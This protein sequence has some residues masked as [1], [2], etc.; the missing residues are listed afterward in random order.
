MYVSKPI[1]ERV[2]VSGFAQT[3]INF[4]NN[5]APALLYSQVQTSGD[6]THPLVRF[7]FCTNVKIYGNY[8]SISNAACFAG[9][10]I[11]RSSG[12]LIQQNA[13]ESCGICVSIA[14]E[15]ESVEYCIGI[16]IRNNQW[17]AA[18]PAYIKV[19]YGFASTTGC[20]NL[21][22]EGN[23]GF[24]GASG[25]ATLYAVDCKKISGFLSRMNQ[26]ALSTTP[27]PTLSYNFSGGQCKAIVIDESITE[28][29]A[30][31][32]PWVSAAFWSGQI[33]EASPYMKW[34]SD[35]ITGERI[36][37]AITT[38]GATLNNVINSNQGGLYTDFQ[39]T[40][41]SPQTI[42]QTSAFPSTSPPGSNFQMTITAANGNTT[43]GHL[44][45]SGHGQFFLKAASNLTLTQ[46]VPVTFI[47]SLLNQQW[48]QL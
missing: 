45:G 3:G 8:L 18:S 4:D 31:A 40:N 22:V 37:N 44:T 2:Y 39:L 20:Y 7:N 11:N 28:Q 30:Y 32:V 14:D 24:K 36:V 33:K 42:N 34:N 17:E 19:G 26:F 10:S 35:C 21:S 29:N 1:V 25:L 47:Y 13:I 41:G 12:V 43:L 15:T 5:N 6:A 9:I 38:T 16:A 23:L 46:N 27:A 48:C